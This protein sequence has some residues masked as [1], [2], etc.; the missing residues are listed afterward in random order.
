[1][2]N[3]SADGARESVAVGPESARFRGLPVFQRVETRAKTGRWQLGNEVSH[4]QSGWVL[5]SGALFQ[6]LRVCTFW[7]CVPPRIGGGNIIKFLAFF[8]FK[9][10][11]IHYKL[12]ITCARKYPKKTLFVP[13]ALPTSYD[14]VFPSVNKLFFFLRHIVATMARPCSRGPAAWSNPSVNVESGR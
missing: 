10:T 4:Q 5:S 11:V 1:M 14:I 9:E 8:Y 7:F 3:Q 13:P 2:G 12:L 6:R